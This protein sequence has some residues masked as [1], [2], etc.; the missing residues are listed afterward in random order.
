MSF[1]EVLFKTD[2]QNDSTGIHIL[3]KMYVTFSADGTE[4]IEVTLALSG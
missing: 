3:K 2:F 1:F 4:V